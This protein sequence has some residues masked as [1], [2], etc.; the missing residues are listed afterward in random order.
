[1]KHLSRRSGKRF[2]PDQREGDSLAYTTPITGPGA[3]PLVYT[4]NGGLNG[5]KGASVQLAS[6]ETK[7]TKKCV[8]KSVS[9]REAFATNRRILQKAEQSRI[10]AAEIDA[11]YGIPLDN[12]R[13]DDD[14]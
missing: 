4:L 13:C 14:L 5:M 2:D 8:G 3:A 7:A 9:Y 11:K 10:D 1:M 12:L 6:I